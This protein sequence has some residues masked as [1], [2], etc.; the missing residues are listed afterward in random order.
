MLFK[1]VNGYLHKVPGGSNG[2]RH[3]PLSESEVDTYIEW[4]NL[5]RPLVIAGVDTVS[6]V[7]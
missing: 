7:P 2:S 1:S 6:L 5:Y 3:V 4:R